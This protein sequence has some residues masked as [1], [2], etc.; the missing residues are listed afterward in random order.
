MIVSLI[1]ALSAENRGIG[2]RGD[3][4]WHLPR[5]LARFRQLTMGHAL[6]FGRKTY[7]SLGGRELPGRKLIVLSRSRLARPGMNT[8]VSLSEALRVAERQL[9]DP[10]PFIGGGGQVF[11]EALERGLADR[12]YLTLVHGAVPA[13][14]FF[15]EYR[16]DQWRVT[17]WEEHTADQ[18]NSLAM[19]FQTLV[20]I[21]AR[22]ASDAQPA[23][24]HG[25][26]AS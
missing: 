11:A 1:A 18:D 12:M 15:P 3:L 24:S 20:R 10:E 14:T 16:Q 9:G 8:A 19:T 5:D 25:S 17:E 22:S 2:W 4:P 26:S 13:D 7:E 21:S 6:I 23:N